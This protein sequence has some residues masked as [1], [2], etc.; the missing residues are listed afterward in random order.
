MKPEAEGLECEMTDILR[1]E[2][3]EY[4]QVTF[5]RK[6]YVLEEKLHTGWLKRAKTAITLWIEENQYSLVCYSEN[7]KNCKFT[8]ERK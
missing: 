3:K 2:G 8:L 1:Y 4:L 6:G 5:I 7:P